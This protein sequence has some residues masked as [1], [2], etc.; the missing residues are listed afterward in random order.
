MDPKHAVLPAHMC[1]RSKAWSS[2]LDARMG[3]PPPPSH[4]LSIIA[5]VIRHPEGPFCCLHPALPSGS[6]TLPS[7]PQFH[8]PTP[9]QYSTNS[10]GLLIW[11]YLHTCQSSLPLVFLEHT[12]H[13][14]QEHAAVGGEFYSMTSDPFRKSK[15]SALRKSLVSRAIHKAKS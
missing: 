13:S 1:P 6:Q 3:P 8:P 14:S 5:M 10:P 11:R 15:C 12:G 4:S 9:S 7:L 2:G